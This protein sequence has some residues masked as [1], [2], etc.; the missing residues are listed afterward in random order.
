MEF[1]RGPDIFTSGGGAAEGRMFGGW[2]VE[3]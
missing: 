2:V 3:G 1:T